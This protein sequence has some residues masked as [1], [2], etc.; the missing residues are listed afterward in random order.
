MH[1]V[2]RF[3]ASATTPLEMSTSNSSC[4]PE[5]SSCPARVLL[6][7]LRSF[8][9]PRR[10]RKYRHE[11]RSDHRVVLVPKDAISF[12]FAQQPTRR[13]RQLFLF[14]ILSP[15]TDQHVKVQMK[16]STSIQVRSHQTQS[17]LVN[18]KKSD[19]QK[20]A[21]R[22]VFFLSPCGCLSLCQLR[23]TKTSLLALGLVRLHEHDRRRKPASCF[24]N[25]R[26]RTRKDIIIH[27]GDATTEDTS[28]DGNPKTNSSTK[29]LYWGSWKT[30]LS[31]PIAGLR[32]SE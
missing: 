26:R 21:T 27:K 29:E 22:L 6:M 30:A 28:S 32:D 8:C 19:P 7:Q 16:A 5:D 18:V 13:G 31:L 25:M 4:T 9:S 2:R 11:E 3:V 23:I 24:K 12:P 20:H 1:A 10:P 15:Q 14:V 17:L